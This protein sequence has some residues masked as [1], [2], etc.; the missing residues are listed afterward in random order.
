M[1]SATHHTDPPRDPVGQAAIP[2]RTIGRLALASA[3]TLLS[4][5]FVLG[6]MLMLINDPAWWRGLLAAGVVSLLA[7]AVSVPLLAWGLHRGLMA[8]VGGYFLTA[9]AKIAISLGGGVLAVYAGGYPALPTMLL[10]VV[11]YLALL[12]AQ[13]T[14]VAR[15]I[16]PAK[17]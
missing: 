16:W 11:F 6:C 2:S 7:T 17:A 1:N 8:A 14:V 10:I 5:G 13:T 4:A 9:V 12:A 3:A 15:T